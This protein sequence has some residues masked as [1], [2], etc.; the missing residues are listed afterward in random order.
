MTK[1]AVAIVFLMLNFYTYHYLASD[2]V[3]PPRTSFD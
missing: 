2:A 1:L 3:I